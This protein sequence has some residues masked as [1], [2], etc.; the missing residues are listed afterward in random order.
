VLLAGGIA[1]V[2]D[3]S[4]VPAARQRGI[5]TMMTVAMLQ[6]ARAHGYETAFLQP[7]EMGEA[8]YRR[9]G[10]R[11]CCVCSVYG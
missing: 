5:G 6:E 4:T 7:S 11:V 2:Y 3:V 1:G 8:L 9:L 10:F